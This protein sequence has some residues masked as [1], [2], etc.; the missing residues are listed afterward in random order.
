MHTITE[1]IQ[2]INT[3]VE[4]IQYNT[5]PKKLYDPIRYILSIGGKRIRPLLMLMGY[6]LYRDDV[7]AIINN[8]LALETYHNFTLLHDDLMDKSDMRR[9]N[10]TVHKKWNDNT[11]ILSGDT[12]LIMAYELFNKGMKN[13]AAW[14]AFIE[15]TLGVC[16]GQQYDI[17]F[18]TRN[19]V[20]EAEYMEMIR[21]KTSLL[22]G[23]ALK[24]GAML[25][26]GDQ[27]DV[28]NL[29][30]FGEKMG[31]AY[32]L[33][34]DLL[35]VYG[36]PTKFQKKLGGDIVDNKK[37]FMLINAYQRANQEQKAELDRWMNTQEFDSAEKIEAVTHI[38]NILGIDKLAQQKIEELFALSLQSLDKVKVDEAKKAELRAFANRL[39]G[40]KY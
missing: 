12:M 11:A 36:D 5:E 29:Y 27:E 22:L 38:Y 39:L 30:K 7:D 20:T 35:D 34:D 2:K 31:L 37:T 13:D 23:Y 17:D 25:G 26:G 24:I 1:L 16:E 3:A 40:R 21:M 9:G 33:Q 28:E 18:E 15:A 4:D 10:P 32:Q 14:T 6:N 19:D 8:A